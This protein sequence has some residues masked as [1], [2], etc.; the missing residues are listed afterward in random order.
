[1]IKEGAEPF[2][3]VG[4]EIKMLLDYMGLE[5]IRYGDRL[6][7]T[8]DVKNGQSDSRL[9]A[10]LLM[11]P[12]VENSF[13]HGA[14]KTMDKAT[15]QLFIETGTEWLDFKITN[16]QL[17]LREKPDERKKIG[18]LNV[19]KRLQLLYPGKHHLDIQSTEDSFTVFMKVKLEKEKI[20]IEKPDQKTTPH[21]I[22][23]YAG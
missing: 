16:S 9:I 15:I 6:E 4:K 5:K 17:V 1:M 23:S 18:L 19:Q 11:L 10:P 12:F 22:M 8:I 2:V 21:E 14:S 13:K 20:A 3:S 7:M